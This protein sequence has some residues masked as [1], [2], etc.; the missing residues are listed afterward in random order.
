MDLQQA[1][2]LAQ[3]AAD[4]VLKIEPRGWERD[5]TFILCTEDPVDEWVGMTRYVRVN[6]DGS[7]QRAPYVAI[8]DEVKDMRR[9]GN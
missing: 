4:P 6:P 1:M 5:G 3:E 9:F 2:V 7:T 8:M